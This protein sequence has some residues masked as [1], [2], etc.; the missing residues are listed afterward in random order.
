MEKL[1]YLFGE[2]E[3]GE[4]PRGRS[5][6]RQRL[7]DAVP[8]L[9]SAGAGGFTIS[10]ADVDDPDLEAVNQ[11]NNMGL[12][13]GQISLWVDHL[14]DRSEIEAIVSDLAPRTAGYLVTESILRDYPSRDWPARAASP[15]IAI[16][17]TFP[18]PAQ[19]D[20]ETFYARWHGSHGPLSLELHPLT[21][22]VRNAVFRPLTAE[23]PRLDAIVSESVASCAVASDVEQFYSGRENR[24]RIVRDLLSFAEIE[25]MSSVVM[26]EYILED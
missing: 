3:A 23:A 16:F 2:T 14:D 24:K 21:R 20:P 22:Y 17:T 25:T 7:F 1:I 6:L 9:V 11:F 15:G 26:R 4:I 13:D 8:G 18:R 12:L 10:V 19:L 5:D